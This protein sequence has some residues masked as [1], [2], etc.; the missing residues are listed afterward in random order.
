MRLFSSVILV[1][2]IHLHVEYCASTRTVAIR[3][4]RET[5]TRTKFNTSRK[6]IQASCTVL[7]LLHSHHLNHG[8]YFN[9]R[10]DIATKCRYVIF[11]IFTY[12]ATPISQEGR[13]QPSLSK[14][15][16]LKVGLLSSEYT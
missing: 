7:M 15:V 9:S 3:L 2:A 14:V 10:I 6:G 8:S 5:L 1:L 13:I 16:E 4:T 12:A 11:S